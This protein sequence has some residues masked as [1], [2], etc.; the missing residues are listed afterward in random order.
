MHVSLYMC[1]YIYTC[2]LYN[3]YNDLLNIYIYIYVYIH[4]CM[5]MYI[6]I[7]IYIYIYTHTALHVACTASAWSFRQPHSQSLA[8]GHCG[9]AHFVPDSLK[10]NPLKQGA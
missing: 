6:Y 5:Y 2:M 9:L 1:I 4:V 10:H 8:D 7:Y 3:L